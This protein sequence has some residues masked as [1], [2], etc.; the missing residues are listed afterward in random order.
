MERRIAISSTIK[1]TLHQMAVY[2]RKLHSYP[3]S[4]YK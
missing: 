3:D 1:A 2:L 4:L